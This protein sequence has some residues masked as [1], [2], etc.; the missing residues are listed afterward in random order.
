MVSDELKIAAGVPIAKKRRKSHV[1]P[2]VSYPRLY[3]DERTKNGLSQMVRSVWVRFRDSSLTTARMPREDFVTHM[4]LHAEI[5]AFGNDGEFKP[6]F[7]M[8]KNSL[9]VVGYVTRNPYRVKLDASLL[10]R[11]GIDVG[12]AGLHSLGLMF[13]GQ[14]LNARGELG[15]LGPARF[16]NVVMRG[17]SA[18]TAA[19]DSTLRLAA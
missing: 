1:Q 16:V 11:F 10:E 14:W 6:R 4:V 5:V 15:P 3:L 18:L 19:D 2:P 17:S 12:D 9:H 8:N 7:S 13:R